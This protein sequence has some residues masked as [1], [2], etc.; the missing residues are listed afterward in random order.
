MRDGYE[1]ALAAALGGRLS[2][3]LVRDMAG[4]EAL[5][6][7]AGPDGGSALLAEISGPEPGAERIARPRRSR[8]S[9]R[10]PGAERLLDLVSGPAAVM[11]LAERLLADAWV[12]ER[13]EDL[14]TEL[15]RD[16]RHARRAG[17]VRRVGRGAPADRGRRGAR[18][19]AAQRTRPADRGERAGG[20]GR[21]GRARGVGAACWRSFAPPSEARGRPKRRCARP[22]A[23]APRAARRGGAPSG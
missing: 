9:R 15:R 20:A 7:R 11:G 5:L 4:A 2:A 3:A 22:S 6:D 12:V 21:A 14:P 13:L 17:V 16:R 8:S 23:H 1:L 19:G 10:W 18:A